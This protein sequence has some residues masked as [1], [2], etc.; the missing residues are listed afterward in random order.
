MSTYCPYCR[1]PVPVDALV[2]STEHI[3]FHTPGAVVIKGTHLSDY[4]VATLR[5]RIP[6]GVIIILLPVGG[7]IESLNEDEMNQLG[8]YKQQPR[9]G[10][11]HSGPVK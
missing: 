2:E 11:A 7:S 1:K 9:Q 8:W 3:K 10:D 5:E 4:E 6:E